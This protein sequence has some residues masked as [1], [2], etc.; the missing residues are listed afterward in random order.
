MDKGGVLLLYFGKFSGHLH[1]QC[2]GG[3]VFLRRSTDHSHYGREEKEDIKTWILTG[4][5]GF[6]R[7]QLNDHTC[8]ERQIDLEEVE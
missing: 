1:H 7:I 2:L 5:G 6:P 3:E 8:V 4:G